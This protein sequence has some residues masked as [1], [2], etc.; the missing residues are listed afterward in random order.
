VNVKAARAECFRQANAA[1]ANIG[2][3]PNA[4]DRLPQGRHTAVNTP[5][6]SVLKDRRKAVFQLI[7]AHGRDCLLGCRNCIFVGR[8]YH[9]SKFRTRIVES[10]QL[11]N[12]APRGETNSF[13]RSQE[14]SGGPIGRGIW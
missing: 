11:L 9:L 3:N 10:G 7:A 2:F 5:P 4:A 14:L 13:N 12:A 1:L 8:H 6:S